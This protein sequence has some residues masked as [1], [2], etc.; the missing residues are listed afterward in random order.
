MVLG[1]LRAAFMSTSLAWSC[2]D[3][4]RGAGALTRSAGA[5]RGSR[6]TRWGRV[7]RPGWWP[8]TGARAALV[9]AGL[10]GSVTVVPAL[11]ACSPRLGPA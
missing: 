5:S 3:S 4:F 1:L 2:G 10:G 7:A 9:A 11:G 8:P 6:F